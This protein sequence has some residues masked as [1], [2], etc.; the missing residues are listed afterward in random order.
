MDLEDILY[1]FTIELNKQII[2]V[3]Y[4]DVV[5]EKTFIDR[6]FLVFYPLLFSLS[7]KHKFSLSYFNELVKVCGLKSRKK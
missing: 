4:S 5:K 7:G 3:V 1:W 6:L 2:L